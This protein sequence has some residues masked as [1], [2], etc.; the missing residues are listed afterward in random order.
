MTTTLNSSLTPTRE[1]IKMVKTEHMEGTVEINANM[2]DV[3]KLQSQ[4]ERI[5]RESSEQRHSFSGFSHLVGGC[6]AF[7]N[8][9]IPLAMNH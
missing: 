3:G 4:Q 5:K 6:R 1:V 9:L 2:E 7:S 8:P